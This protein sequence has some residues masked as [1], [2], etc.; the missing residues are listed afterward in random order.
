MYLTKYFL[1]YGN[2]FSG[3]EPRLIMHAFHTEMRENGNQKKKKIEK[4]KKKIPRTSS[5]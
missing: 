1:K 2:K 3:I 4:N 5:V